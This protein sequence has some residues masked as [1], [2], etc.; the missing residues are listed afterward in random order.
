METLGHDA[1]DGDD[2]IYQPPPEYAVMRWLWVMSE[3]H[4]AAYWLT[5]PL[6]QARWRIWR[7]RV[8]APFLHEDPFAP[9]GD[10]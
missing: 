6:W 7:W 10:Q 9:G 3:R 1:T 4:I 8:A 5:V 2:C